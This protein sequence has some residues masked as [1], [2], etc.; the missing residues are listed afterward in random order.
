MLQGHEDARW[1]AHAHAAEQQ[2]TGSE[3]QDGLH[4]LQSADPD[5]AAGRSGSGGSADCDTGDACAR[6]G[7]AHFSR[8]GSAAGSGY[9]AATAAVSS[10]HFPNL[11]LS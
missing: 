2:R 6:V 4:V 11:K 8:A 5:I 7:Y 1:D 10:L 3:L 9:F